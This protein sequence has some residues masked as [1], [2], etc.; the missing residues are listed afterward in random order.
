M[1]R[2]AMCVILLL[3]LTLRLG[4]A[5]SRNTN[6]D[7]LAALPDQ[8]E[9]L[10]LGRNLLHGQGL[11]FYDPRF[12]DEVRAFRTPGYPLLIAACGGNVRIIRIAA[13]FL[14]TSTALAVYLLARR[15]LSERACLFAA[16]LVATNL[17]MV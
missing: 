8:R 11:K 9:Y 3:A 15:W 10:E 13:A 17:Y 5:I 4:W 2:T 12:D 6:E 16:T 7:S 1:Q 14:D